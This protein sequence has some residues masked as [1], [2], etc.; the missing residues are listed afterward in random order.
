[1]V[2]FGSFLNGWKLPTISSNKDNKEIDND[3]RSMNILYPIKVS[4][5]TQSL[6]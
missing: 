3:C 6:T 5:N 4:T 2:L 1:M